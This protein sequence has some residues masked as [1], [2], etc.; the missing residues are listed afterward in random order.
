[1]EHT[2]LSKKFIITKKI[3]AGAFGEIHQAIDIAS[4]DE[5]AIKQEPA[6]SKHQQLFYEAKLYQYLHQDETAWEKGIPKMYYSG[7]EGDKNIMVMELLGSSLE[8]LF[9]LCGRKFSLKTS[10]ILGEQMLARVEYVHS[11]RFLHR[12][13]KPDNFAIGRGKTQKKVFLIDF[14]LAKKYMS[15][16]NIHIPYRDGKS[17]TGTARYASINTHLGIEQGRRDDVEALAYIMIYFLK[18]ALP[19]QNMKAK[20]KKEKYEKIC[21][22]KVSTPIEVLCKGCPPELAEYLTY[23]RKLKFEEK[24]DYDY[25][26]SLIRKS[27]ERSEIV[28]DGIYDWTVAAPEKKPKEPIKGIGETKQNNDGVIPNAKVPDDMKMNSNV[29]DSLKITATSP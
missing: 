14:G 4:K 23:C 28:N 20:D 25:L 26:R 13:L 24:P 12:D 3:G 15:R 19:W 29:P 2:K 8:D 18:G 5:V 27:M 22:K 7:T 16:D 10:L 11:R 21:Q 9:N 6:D 1:M 17:L